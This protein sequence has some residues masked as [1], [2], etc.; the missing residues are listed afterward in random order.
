MAS[1]SITSSITVATTNPFLVSDNPVREYNI[2]IDVGYTDD[3]NKPKVSH[4]I[5]FGIF[6]SLANEL[7]SHH[8][9]SYSYYTGKLMF[10]VNILLDS[11]CKV[12]EIPIFLWS[13]CK[14]FHS[15]IDWLKLFA[16]FSV[17][18][19]ISASY[20]SLFIL[21]PLSQW[22]L[23]S[24]VIGNLWA[25]FND[26]SLLLGPVNSVSSGLLKR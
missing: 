23:K 14:W 8:I 4:A 2:S 17:L 19:L 25:C 18:G 6:L 7:I 15:L 22:S 16:N 11:C 24:D 5:Q 20:I 9:Y 12:L 10:P 13:S 1:I 26:E 3:A 21:V